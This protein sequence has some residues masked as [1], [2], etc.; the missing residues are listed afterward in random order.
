MLVGPFSKSNSLIAIFF[1]SLWIA[2]KGLLVFFHICGEKSDRKK[3]INGS[4]NMLSQQA[5]YFSFKS[6]EL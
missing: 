3:R 2:G 5:K 6:A 4:N 1:N